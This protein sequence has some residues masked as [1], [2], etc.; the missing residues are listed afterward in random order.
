MDYALAYLY[1][2]LGMILAILATFAFYLGG[3]RLIAWVTRDDGC[4]QADREAAF[5][6]Q[7]AGSGDNTGGGAPHLAGAATPPTG[8][9]ALQGHGDA[10]PRP[11]Y[12][13]Q[14][15]TPA[16]IYDDADNLPPADRFS[17]RLP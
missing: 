13:L 14:G 2:D 17:A 12:S 8:F 11:L 4:D 9:C 7:F 6:Q 15:Y 1:A 5:L 16:P 3:I 10:F